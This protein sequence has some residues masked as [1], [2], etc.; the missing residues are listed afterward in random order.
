MPSTAGGI[1]KR[2][3]DTTRD[4]IDTLAL[5][6]KHSVTFAGHAMPVLA[7]GGVAL[8]DI[9]VVIGGGATGDELAFFHDV[10]LPGMTAA[11]RWA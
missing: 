6:A 10:L 2:Q 11:N 7:H 9:A 5:G 3:V 4:G 8:H 1:A